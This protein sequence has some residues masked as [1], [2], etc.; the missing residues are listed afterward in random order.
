MNYLDFTSAILSLVGTVY[1]VKANTKMWPI[2]ILAI[3]L[4]SIL[5]FKYKMY[6][7]LILE[8]VYLICSIYGWIYWV[9]STRKQNVYRIKYHQ[10]ISVIILWIV[11]VYGTH[12]LMIK[13]TNRP[14]MVEAI[15]VGTSIIA[16][17]LSSRKIIECWYGWIIA[18]SVFLY[19][20]FYKGLYF[21]TILF[22]C[23]LVL[24]I[25]GLLNWYKLEL[26]M[27]TFIKKNKP[28]L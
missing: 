23:Y 9:K 18:D 25:L 20:M 5:Y 26:S 28:E 1:F 3:I 17:I 12:S 24:A 4:N 13:F 16:Q 14:S 22:S 2:Y 19:L 6:A 10:L 7:S 21:H 11:I 27:G 8:N 15:A